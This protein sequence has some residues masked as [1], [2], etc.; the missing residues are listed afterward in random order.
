MLHTR[1]VYFSKASAF[2]GHYLVKYEELVFIISPGGA[3]DIV[4]HISTKKKKVKKYQLAN[5][6]ARLGRFSQNR[7]HITHVFTRNQTMENLS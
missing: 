5:Y 4:L 6:S 3:R 2:I 1:R 7:L